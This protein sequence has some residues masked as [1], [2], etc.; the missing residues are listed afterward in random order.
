[1]KNLKKKITAVLASAAI[2]VGSQGGFSSSAFIGGELVK[3][4]LGAA[5][6]STAPMIFTRI[7]SYAVFAYERVSEYF[8]VEKYKGFR[9]TKETMKELEK[10]VNDESE[11]K[12]YGQEKAKEQMMDVLSGVAVRIDNLKRKGSD[13]KEIRGNIVYIIGKP[14]TGKTK[15][16]YAIAN[17]F[18]K[19]PEKTSVFCHSE[20][21]TGES[22]LGTQL[23][24][25][26][27]TKNIGEKRQKNIFTGSDGL[28]AKDEE[29]P[30]LK[31]LLSW[32]ESVVIIDEYE[33]MKEK[34]AKPG[35]V[36]MINGLSLPTGATGAQYDNSADEILRSIA[37]T[38]K[39]KFMNKEVDC[40]K[41]LFLITTNE[42]REE[43][44]KNFGIGGISGGGA[45]RLNIIEFDTLSY[46]AC[47]KIVKDLVEDVC[48]TLVDKSGPF[49]I[50]SVTFE[51]ESLDAMAKYIF[52]DSVMQG[53]AKNKL[54]D[55]LYSLF[56]K[57]MGEDSGKNIKISF[58]PAS[59]SQSE[60][61]VK[62]IV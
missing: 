27:A 13:V 53:R 7:F 5:L 34:S 59:E 1:M 14:G 28:V 61:F 45:Q 50:S 51:K 57:S 25:T 20:S 24:K 62:K 43:V 48:E 58:V 16:C 54:E 49:K 33:K 30:I 4:T 35:S 38:G 8:E 41:T 23:F 40:S 37:S 17:A 56:A 22:E 31:H 9:D 39:Y 21:I 60:H 55:K 18:L 32:E 29:T 46:D 52:E 2:L 26:V 42:T 36:M 12:I 3:S 15:M 19:H 11:I 44:E 6:A 10:I 47:Y